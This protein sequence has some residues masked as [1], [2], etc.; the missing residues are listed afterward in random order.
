MRSFR[1]SLLLSFKPFNE[2]SLVLVSMNQTNFVLIKSLCLMKLICCNKSPSFAAQHHDLTANARMDTVRKGSITA[3]T[4]LERCTVRAR[5]RHDLGSKEY[6]LGLKTG[7]IWDRKRH[8]LSS[9]QAR[10]RLENGTIWARSWHT[11]TQ[12]QGSKLSTFCKKTRDFTTSDG[13]IFALTLQ[14]H[15]KIE[16]RAD[17]VLKFRIH[18]IWPSCAPQL[19]SYLKTRKHTRDKGVVPNYALKTIGGF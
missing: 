13:Y 3:R 14:K 12:R 4:G 10:I 18:D 5:N 16:K 1:N 8:Q 15:H 11:N 6:L 17:K 19:T 2:C 7:T 9:K